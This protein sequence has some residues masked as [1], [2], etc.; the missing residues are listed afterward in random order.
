MAGPRRMALPRALLGTMIILKQLRNDFPKASIDFKSRMLDDGSYDGYYLIVNGKTI[1]LHITARYLES[2]DLKTEKGRTMYWLFVKY[3]M[4]IF[5]CEPLA[6]SLAD[7][8][9]ITVDEEQFLGYI[10]KMRGRQSK[11]SEAAEGPKPAEIEG[12]EQE[13][14]ERIMSEMKGKFDDL[15]WYRED[16]KNNKIDK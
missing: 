8:L 12:D 16:F 13:I 2:V 15:L 4:D 14:Y 1:M 7:S 10:R 9:R 3:M 11:K 5:N 6:G